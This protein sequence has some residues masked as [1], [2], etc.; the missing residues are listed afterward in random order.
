MK[1]L[2]IGSEGSMGKRYQAI[3]DY[4]G[5]EKVLAD[6]KDD[7]IEICLKAMQSDRII[8]A[9]PTETHAQ[10]LHW[11]MPQGKPILCEKPVCKN[12]DELVEI[13]SYAK[14]NKTPLAMVMQ[15]KYLVEPESEG[16]SSYNYFRHGNDGLIW[17]CF[18]IIALAKGE[19]TLAEDSPYWQCQINGQRLSIES[20]DSA[21]VTMLREWIEK[22][23]SDVENLYAI[24]EKVSKYA[25]S[26]NRHRHPGA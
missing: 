25:N 1:V 23:Y 16:P 19:V 12:L 7:R 10:I 4:I 5:H 8:I 14:W 21:Y 20:M 11:V 6:K 13:I 17:D 3:L 18:Q 9:T 2:I 26:A 22:P 24:H 15:Y